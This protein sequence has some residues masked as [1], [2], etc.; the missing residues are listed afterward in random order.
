MNPTR[1]ALLVLQELDTAIDVVDKAASALPHKQKIVV[2]RNSIAEGEQVIERVE[3]AIHE[4][5][6]QCRQLT[7]SVEMHKAKSQGEQERLNSSANNHREV[8][9]IA[10]DIAHIASEIEKLESQ[11]LELLE[12][13]DQY[14]T[15]IVTYRS[16]IEQLKKVEKQVLAK[17]K[18]EYT[19]L[20]AERQELLAKTV[21]PKSVIG[22]ET[23]KR[24]QSLREQK[25]GVAVCLYR[26]GACSVC[27]ISV[28]TAA[29]G[30]ILEADVYSICP[31][32]RR[33]MIVEEFLDGE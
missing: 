5:D 8:E 25:A 28:P 19:R 18:K 3:Q 23:L 6:K 33:L 24:Y 4:I 9:L 7:T 17:Y 29:R 30:P 31:G 14:T 2:I 27:H 15:R 12:R 11:E 22:E 26:N 21:E 16:K 13:K 1:Q 10:K 32:C 20:M